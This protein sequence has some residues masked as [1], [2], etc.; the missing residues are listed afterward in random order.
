VFTYLQP[1]GIGEV[2]PPEGPTAGGTT[3][4]ITGSHLTGTTSVS[5]GSVPAASFT[6][7]SAKSISAVSPAGG[8]GSVTLTVATPGGAAKAHFTFVAAP[9]GPQGGSG[10]GPSGSTA[11]S[12]G[13]G[14]AGGGGGVLGFGPL[15]NASLLSRTLTVLGDAR[16][17]IRL[18]WRGAG[19]CAGTVRL[20]VRVKA[21]KHLR[22][23]TIG[24]GTF[25]IAAGRTRTVTVKLN[26][27]GR[28][29]LAARHGRMNASLLI[30]SVAGHVSSARTANVRL[31]VQKHKK[32]KAKGK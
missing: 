13:S 19:T 15:C 14:A 22:T 23:K 29:L 18:S 28:T 30:S 4:T 12:G 17:T 7:L 25:T 3:V 16:A 11:G 26:R 1:P 8:V 10:G 9:A 31:A 27:L 6:V 24:T 5:F 20:S 32:A 21:G 2:S